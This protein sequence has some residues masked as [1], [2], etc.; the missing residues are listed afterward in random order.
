MEYL[1]SDSEIFFYFQGKLKPVYLAIRS[2]D[3]TKLFFF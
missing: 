3:L 2:F 1:Y